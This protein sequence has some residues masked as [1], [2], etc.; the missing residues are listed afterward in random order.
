MKPRKPYNLKCWI[1]ST[2]SGSAHFFTCARPGRETGAWKQVP[3]Q[4]V[5]VWVSALQKLGDNTTIISLL[6]R[7]P[8]GR[9]EFSFYS[10][11]GGFDTPSER[12]GRP[13]FQEWM[14]QHFKAHH[15]LIREH[16]TYDYGNICPETLDAVKNDIRELISVGHTVIVVDSGGETRTGQVRK[17]MGAEEDSC[18]KP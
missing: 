4:S 2:P 5:R 17:H 7:K 6:G 9:S 1:V 13:T 14:D 11:C 12:D 8:D 18:S 10:F 16:P 3:D 15:I